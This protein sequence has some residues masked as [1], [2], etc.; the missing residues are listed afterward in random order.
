MSTYKI[1]NYNLNQHYELEVDLIETYDSL[2][3]TFPPTSNL[4]D[5][6]F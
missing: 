2:E 1:E 5:I 3:K 4:D 6:S